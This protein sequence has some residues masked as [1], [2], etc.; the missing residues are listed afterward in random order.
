ML[1]Y[2][3]CQPVL[4]PL[5]VVSTIDRITEVHRYGRIANVI[6][7]ASHPERGPYRLDVKLYQMQDRRSHGRRDSFPHMQRVSRHNV[8]QVGVAQIPSFSKGPM[9]YFT[10]ICKTK[11]GLHDGEWIVDVRLSIWSIGPLDGESP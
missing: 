2:F 3:L 4:D 5:Q 10:G 8:L 6:R 11:P 7:V 9:G 1:H